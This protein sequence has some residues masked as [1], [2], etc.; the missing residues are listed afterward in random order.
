MD[1]L[2]ESRIRTVAPKVWS[3]GLQR[4]QHLLQGR[5]AYPWAHTTMSWG[6]VE[7][8]VVGLC[9]QSFRFKRFRVEP[10]NFHF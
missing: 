4:Q 1:L 6:A 2:P 7:A 8:Q 3:P 10:E 5:D 9:P